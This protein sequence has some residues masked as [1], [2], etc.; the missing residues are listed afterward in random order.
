MSEQEN[1]NGKQ[2]MVQDALN[3][4]LTNLNRLIKE[5]S[6]NITDRCVLKR[7]ED[8]LILLIRRTEH[9]TALAALTAALN[10]V[11]RCHSCL[12]RKKANFYGGIGS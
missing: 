8:D 1:P 3:T 6:H 9:H 12:D 4:E 2:K 10:E 5:A 11:R 7:V